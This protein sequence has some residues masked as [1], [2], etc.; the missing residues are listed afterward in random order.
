[1]FLFSNPTTPKYAQTVA[2][3][4]FQLNFIK[5]CIDN[6]PQKMRKR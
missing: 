3:T 4:E 2:I 5:S 6:I 1:M